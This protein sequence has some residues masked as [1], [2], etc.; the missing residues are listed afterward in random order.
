M[1]SRVARAS[2]SSLHL[3]RALASPTAVKSFD[4]SKRSASTQPP[5]VAVPVFENKALASLLAS[6][7]KPDPKDL[8]GID[9]DESGDLFLLIKSVLSVEYKGMAREYQI[10][11]LASF[12][13]SDD[14]V[15]KWFRHLELWK[16]MGAKN[17]DGLDAHDSAL[18]FDWYLSIMLSDTSQG[19]PAVEALIED[20]IRVLEKEFVEAE[21]GISKGSFVPVEYSNSAKSKVMT[22]SHKPWLRAVWKRS[23]SEPRRLLSEVFSP[24]FVRFT[25]TETFGDAHYTTIRVDNVVIGQ[26]PLAP[27]AADAEVQACRTALLLTG[28]QLVKLLG[29]CSTFSKEE[30]VD[31]G[32]VFEKLRGVKS[33][34]GFARDQT[35]SPANVHKGNLARKDVSSLAKLCVKNP[36]EALSQIFYPLPAFISYHGFKDRPLARLFVGGKCIA[37]S[38]KAYDKAEVTNELLM[39]LLDTFRDELDVL[40][41]CVCGSKVT[42]A[43]IDSVFF[44]IGKLKASVMKAPRSLGTRPIISNPPPPPKCRPLIKWIKDDKALLAHQKT[45]TKHEPLDYTNF[46]YLTNVRPMRNV[47]I[48]KTPRMANAGGIDPQF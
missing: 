14:T 12:L 30:L 38:L 32:K 2:R 18:Y 48:P 29:T 43:Y 25:T 28:N 37:E 10:E 1:L 9:F 7:K 44:L 40:K 27:S 13:T 22:L 41:E 8:Y 16:Y 36:N 45:S 21:L 6:S 19:P 24:A 35:E 11:K 5:K 31:L 15:A 17:G 33:F 4:L 26:G 34:S 47:F 3:A 46:S 20:I 23:Q 42:N 39:G